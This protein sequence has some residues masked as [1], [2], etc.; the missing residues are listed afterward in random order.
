MKATKKMITEVTRI[1]QEK[2]VDV[3]E[4]LSTLSLCSLSI[5][6]AIGAEGVVKSAKPRIQPQ[7]KITRETDKAVL[8]EMTSPKYNHV[9]EDYP[10]ITFWCPKSILVDGRAP[11]WKINQEV[12]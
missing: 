10:V 11:E 2:N 1:A 7:Q 3:N 5:Y 8:F 4:A 12:H 9:I 6:K